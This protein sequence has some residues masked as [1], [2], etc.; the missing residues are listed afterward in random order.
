MAQLQSLE[1]EERYETMMIIT[2]PD[3]KG[4]TNTNIITN[5]AR[6]TNNTTDTNGYRCKWKYR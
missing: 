5:A 6:N 1:K 4:N 2:N 3:G